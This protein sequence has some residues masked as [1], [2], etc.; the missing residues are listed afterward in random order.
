MV[1][2]EYS[3]NSFKYP[4]TVSR[5]SPVA[6]MMVCTDPILSSYSLKPVVIGCRVNAL[7]ILLAEFTAELVMFANAVTPIT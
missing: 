5:L 2:S 3:F 6:A 1:L 4:F 7:T